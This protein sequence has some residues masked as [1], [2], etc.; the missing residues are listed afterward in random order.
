MREK[1]K[2]GK[3]NDKKV[4]E[5]SETEKEGSEKDHDKKIEKMEGEKT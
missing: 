5:D 4:D 2:L 1:E 3:K